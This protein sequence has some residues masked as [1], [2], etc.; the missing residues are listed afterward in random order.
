MGVGRASTM[1]P[2][3]WTASPNRRG[4]GSPMRSRPPPRAGRRLGGGQRAARP[5][6]R[7]DGLGQ[8]PRR[9]P[10]GDRPARHR[11]APPD[12]G[13]LS[14][15]LRLPAQ[16]PRGRRR[17]E[18][19]LAPR[20][21]TAGRR[22]GSGMPLP[23]VR[24]GIRTGDTPPTERRAFAHP[25]AGRPH[26]HPGVALPGAD[27]GVRARPRRG[28][29]GHRRRGPRGRRDQARRAPGA[30]ARAPRRDARGTRRSGSAQRVGLSATVRPIETVAHFLGGN[31]PP[32]EGGRPVRSSSRRHEAHGRRRRPGPGPVGRR[33]GGAPGRGRTR[34]AGD[35]VDLSGA[36][37]RPPRAPRSGR[38]SR[39]RSSTSSPPTVRRWCSRTPAAAPSG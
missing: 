17:A 14:R 13:A 35:A 1:A 15:A 25:P 22:R 19:A 24:V 26:H 21:D 32:E 34:T 11:P 36:S 28:A 9:L 16:G 37:R 27:L 23:Q 31:R 30:L 6:R 18:P 39:R 33:L 4:R 20:R 2:W 8:D 12:R 29:H 5:R 38:T 10:L 7:A 3:C